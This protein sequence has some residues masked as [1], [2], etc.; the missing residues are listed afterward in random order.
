MTRSSTRTFRSGNSQ[1]VRLPKEVAFAEETELTLVRSGD[2]LTIYPAR[3]SVQDL[4][5]RLAALPKPGA[6]EVRDDEDLPER[7]G[8]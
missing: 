2:V 1:A 4:V 5:A 6:V 7:S 3:G 8:L